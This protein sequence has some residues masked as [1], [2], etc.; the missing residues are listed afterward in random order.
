MGVKV[1]IYTMEFCPFCLRAKDL[2]KR[3]GVDFKEVLV[4]M[5]DDSQWEE[6]EK[7]SGMK[8]MPQIFAGDRL[9]GGYVDLEALDQT[10]QLLS[11][12]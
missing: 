8:T 10:D 1:T 11:L 12:K 5:D 7:R 2:L 6:L 9:I 3:R 4:P